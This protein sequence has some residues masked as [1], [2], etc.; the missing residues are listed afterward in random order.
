MLVDS[1]RISAEQT[2]VSTTQSERLAYESLSLT[3]YL[4]IFLFIYTNSAEGPY[5]H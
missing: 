3:L 4:L 5:K 1:L 2:F